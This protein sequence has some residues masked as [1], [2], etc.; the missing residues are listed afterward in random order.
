MLGQKSPKFIGQKS[1]FGWLYNS[2][3]QNLGHTIF[4]SIK[5]TIFIAM[6]IQHLQYIYFLVRHFRF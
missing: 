5:K 6:P 1:A 3:V 4:S 2:V